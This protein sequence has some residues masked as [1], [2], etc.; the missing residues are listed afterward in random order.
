M[1][2]YKFTIYGQVVS[3]KRNWTIGYS[4]RSKRYRIV[5]KQ[6]YKDWE[7][8]AVA[9]LWIGKVQHDIIEPLDDPLWV[10]FHIYYFGLGIIDLTN[11]IQG[12]EDALKAAGI[13]R[14]DSLI[15]SVDGSRKHPVAD[16]SQARVEITIRPFEK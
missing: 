4:K 5:L 2:E 15:M 3:K 11:L 1:F 7:N 8:R 10:E 14:D 13:I 9:Q 16:E 6:V 12:P